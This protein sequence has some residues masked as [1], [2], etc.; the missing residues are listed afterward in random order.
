MGGRLRLAILVWAGSTNRGRELDGYEE[1]PGHD[2]GLPL[3]VLGGSVGRRGQPTDRKRGNRSQMRKGGKT[4][5]SRVK[6]TRW[7]NMQC[8]RFFFGPNPLFWFLNRHLNLN[9]R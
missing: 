3:P 6:T 8:V 7:E 9:P 4:G 1:G 2:P 5:A